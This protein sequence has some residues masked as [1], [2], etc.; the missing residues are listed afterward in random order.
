MIYIA[1]PYFSGLLEII[2]GIPSFWESIEHVL[3]GN[4]VNQMLL[5]MDS[6]RIAMRAKSSLE[7]SSPVST[8]SDYLNQF[9]EDRDHV[10]ECNAFKRTRCTVRVY[11]LSISTSKMI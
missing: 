1:K 4:H 2:F 11:C 8:Q 10:Y 6:V 7:I 5:T 9:F 3:V